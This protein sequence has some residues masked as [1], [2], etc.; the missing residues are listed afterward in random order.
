[1]YETVN[2]A[3]RELVIEKYGKVVRLPRGWQLDDGANRA[4]PIL[5]VAY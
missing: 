4:E 1:M 5:I 2:V 3:F